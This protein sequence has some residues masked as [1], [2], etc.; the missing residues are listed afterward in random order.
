MTTTD[1]SLIERIELG[2]DSAF[3]LLV[4]RYQ[5][6]VFQTCI[7]FVHNEE[8]AADLTQEVFIR[9]YKRLHTFK[10]NSTFSTWIYRI[11]MNMSLNFLRKRKVKHL[12]TRIDQN[13]GK[14]EII[15]EERTD[16][17]ILRRD[18]KKK[19]QRIL[20]KLTVAQRKAFVLS[21]YQE[22]SNQEL[23]DVMEISIKA[24]ESLLYRARTRLREI[25]T[26]NNRFD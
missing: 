26:E 4:K 21:H 2:D 18:E 25:L 9:V 8:D 5:Q 22:L 19:I 7:G 3:E 17:N 14:Q 24:A 15:S 16:Q 6:K 13:E 10:G 20:Q 23:A 1:E 11:S 12:F